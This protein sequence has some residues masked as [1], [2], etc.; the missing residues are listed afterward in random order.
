MSKYSVSTS[1]SNSVA[2]P[3][4]AQLVQPSLA[5]AKRFF[6]FIDCPSLLLALKS[7]LA[8]ALATG[9]AFWLDI[10]PTI[11]AIT[12]FMIQQSYVGSTIYRGTLRFVGGTA[13]AFLALVML[14]LFSQDRILFIGSI[15]LCAA[16]IVYFLQGTR[17]WYA[18][19]LCLASLVVVGYGSVEHPQ[20]AFDFAVNWI[21]GIL[22]AVVCVSI[23]RGLLWPNFTANVFERQ[24]RGNLANCRKL[25]RMTMDSLVNGKE[26]SAEL[27]GLE[28]SIIRGLVQPQTTLQTALFDSWQVDRFEGSYNHFLNQLNSLV[29]LAIGSREHLRIIQTR[30]ALADAIQQSQTVRQI[31]SELDNRM[32]DLIAALEMPRDGTC[33]RPAID[34]LDAIE[35]LSGR[36]VDAIH[37]AGTELFDRAALLGLISKL[38]ELGKQIPKLHDCLATVETAEAQ[39]A[40]RADAATHQAAPPFMRL[41]YSRTICLAS[42]VLQNRICAKSL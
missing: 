6:D 13:G 37:E 4:V 28:Q 5:F 10:S 22:L 38:T 15:S 24:L 11:T 34:A 1:S 36:M 40:A 8:I 18:Y 2:E 7:C 31:A 42:S 19:I 41:R 23:V 20:Y 17:Y 21:S 30:P 35:V 9:L 29:K 39:A 26:H 32:Q 25:L 16:L 27:D 12:A 33:R 14:A 3:R